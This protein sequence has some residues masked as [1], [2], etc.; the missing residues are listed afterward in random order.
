MPYLNIVSWAGW[1]AMFIMV[2]L[3]LGVRDDVAQSIKHCEKTIAEAKAQTEEN[4]R[5]ALQ[6][7]HDQELTRLNRQLR[8]AQNAVNQAIE[9]REQADNEATAAIARLRQLQEDI[10]NDSDAPLENICS[11]LDMPADIRSVYNTS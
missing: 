11:N 7:A 4:I 5:T 6:E 10:A 9:D 2:W 1:P 3:Y 8:A